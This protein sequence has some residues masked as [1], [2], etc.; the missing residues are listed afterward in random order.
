MNERERAE[1]ESLLEWLPVSRLAGGSY[2]RTVEALLAANGDRERVAA[3]L[4]CTRRSLANRLHR[5]RAYASRRGW[6]PDVKLARKLAPSFYIERITHHERADGETIQRW[7]K[8]RAGAEDQQAAIESFISGLIDPAVRVAPTELPS[9]ADD[10]L[11]AVVP[12]G[13]PHLGM[14]AHEPETGAN[15]DLKIAESTMLSANDALFT[16]MPTV[17]KMVLAFMGD[18][19]HANDDTART[20]KSGHVLDVDGRHPHVAEAAARIVRRTIDNALEHAAEVVF[21]AVQGNHDPLSSFWLSL[22]VRLLYENEPRVTVLDTRRHINVL[23]HGVNLLAFTHGHGIKRTEVDRYVAAAF[24]D[25][26]GAAQI[27]HA[28]T[29]HVHH[30]HVI[31]RPGMLVESIRTLAAKDRYAAHNGYLSGRDLKLDLWHRDYGRVR[32]YTHTVGLR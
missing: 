13:D 16:V 9:L 12:Y 8:L 32:R 15:F 31:E 3:E 5:A 1:L 19:F 23:A 20:P 7:L 2:R 18:N 30:D 22:A 25:E 17:S 26:W 28:Y 21:I 29:G 6:N 11:V 14:L 10:K 4:N 27:R 24:A